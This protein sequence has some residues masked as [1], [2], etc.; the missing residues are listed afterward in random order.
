MIEIPRP[1]PAVVLGVLCGYALVSLGA[2]VGALPALPPALHALAL[3]FSLLGLAAF[4][5]TD[6]P[7]ATPRLPAPGERGYRDTVLRMAA[8]IDAG[9]P[10]TRGRS[11][12][13][14]RA[15]LA[16]GRELGLS[17]G[18]LCDLELAALL[19]DVGR[20]AIQHDALRKPGRLSEEERE[21]VRT[22]PEVGFELVRD[23]PGLEGVAEI[24]RAHHEQP[25]G[26]GYPRGL[27][28]RE[29]P[30]GSRI[31]MVAA[32]F[33]AM[34]RDRPY[35]RGL[36]VDE[37][38]KELRDHAGTM[39]FPEVVDAFLRLQRAGALFADA[40]PE[41]WE[42]FAGEIPEER[43]RAAL[44]AGVQPRKEGTAPP[45]G[46]SGLRPG[47]AGEPRP[48]GAAPHGEAAAGR[49]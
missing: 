39:F 17:R 3:L 34:V 2:A 8:V 37:A 11:Y 49:R 24:I 41:E 4:A 36:S 16:V 47:R 27:R 29:I 20:S 14:S 25:D 38:L 9:D 45:E 1:L 18:E 19:H 26:R 5:R 10:F 23:I 21:V 15:C 33:E 13:I 31:L 32:A 40:D 12:R 46:G 7:G 30:V 35:R 42:T 6:R 43:D 22:H 44:L 28:G 48:E